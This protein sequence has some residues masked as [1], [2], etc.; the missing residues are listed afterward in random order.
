M[1][2]KDVDLQTPWIREML[3]DWL[4]KLADRGWQEANWV[5]RASSSS[6]LDEVLDF[7]DDSGVLSEPEGKIGF[8]LFDEGEAAAML[9]LGVALDEA[10]SVSAS[11]DVAVIRSPSWGAV[12]DTAREALRIMSR[13]TCP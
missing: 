11:S 8:T 7:F 5:N 2:R 12:V 4:G 3:T 6:G 9:A 1:P 13:H 10:V